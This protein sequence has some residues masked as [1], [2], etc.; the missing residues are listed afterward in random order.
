MQLSFLGPLIRI[1]DLERLVKTGLF[2]ANELE[3]DHGNIP[4]IPQQDDEQVAI[5]DG[6]DGEEEEIYVTEKWF[7]NFLKSGRT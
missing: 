7:S 6:T 1:D 2:M 4:H 3:A 5:E